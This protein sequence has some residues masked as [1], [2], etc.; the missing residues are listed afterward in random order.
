MN[1]GYLIPRSHQT[2]NM[3]KKSCFIKQ[4]GH[5]TKQASNVVSTIHYHNSAKSQS[6]FV[7]STFFKR[8]KDEKYIGVGEHDN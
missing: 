4:V 8:L 1:K 7:I 6:I 3:F 5:L 2:L